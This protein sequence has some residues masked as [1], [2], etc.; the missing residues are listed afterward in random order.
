[1]SILH[2][3]DIFLLRR[4]KEDDE[5]AFKYLF[6]T[7]YVSLYRLAFFYIKKD[8][9]AEEITLDVFTAFWEK[10]K[11][12]EIQISIKAYLIT[13][14]RNRSMNYIRDNKSIYTTDDLSLLDS[15]IEEY[16]LEMKE[17]EQLIDAAISS[18]PDKCKQVFI[19]SRT[20]NLTNREIASQM[21]ITTKTVE[22]QITKALKHIREHLGNSYHY[23]W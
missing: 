13:S 2:T 15:T 3:D 22:A 21:N 18:L 20:E 7:Y 10:R 8:M 16:S 14:T 11:T 6:E 9:V 19:K 12:I 23:L 4:I 17:L 1:M 5:T